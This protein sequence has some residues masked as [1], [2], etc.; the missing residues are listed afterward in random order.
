MALESLTSLIP[1]IGDPALSTLDYVKSSFSILLERVQVQS[2][3]PATERIP[4][5]P[6]LQMRRVLEEK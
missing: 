2:V 4:I 1:N 6:V 3:S 5:D